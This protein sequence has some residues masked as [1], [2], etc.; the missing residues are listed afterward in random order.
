MIAACFFR[1]LFTRCTISLYLCVS[2]MFS[3]CAGHHFTYNALPS[4]NYAPSFHN[5]AKSDSDPDRDFQLPE[6]S[7]LDKIND[8]TGFVILG[9]VIAA[10]SVAAIAIPIYMLKK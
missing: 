9:I 3:A 6:D 8:K 5:A 4:Q 2:L 7:T 10:A 1:N